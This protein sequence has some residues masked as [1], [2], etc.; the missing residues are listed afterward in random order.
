[1]SY[2]DWTDPD[3]GLVYE[4]NYVV[5]Q[6]PDEGQEHYAWRLKS[7][8]ND[9]WRKLPPF[10]DVEPEIAEHFHGP[11][12]GIA[13]VEILDLRTGKG[14]PKESDGIVL[15]IDDRRCVCINMSG[16]LFTDE[17]V[18]Y[19]VIEGKNPDEVQPG[20]V[21]HSYHPTWIMGPKSL[22]DLLQG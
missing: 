17:L 4:I 13:L 11:Q 16:Q 20:D 22:R 18:A 3:T 8:D 21:I 19:E 7:N 2:Y 5:T 6:H 12:I 10:A 9:R 14:L 15:S 1:M